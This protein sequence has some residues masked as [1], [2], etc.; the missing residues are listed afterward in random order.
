VGGAS[1][2]LWHSH[3]LTE[4]YSAA[5][6]DEVSSFDDYLRLEDRLFAELQEDVYADVG[7]GPAYALVRY[8]A[9]SLADPEDDEPNW[10]RSFELATEA[11]V[12]G[13]LLLHGMSDSP[14]SLRA[15]AETLA[16]QG[17]W[18]IGL[19]LP[20]H[21]TAPSGLTH[22]TMQEMAGAVRLAM[23]HLASKLGEKP[24]H[25]VGYSTGAGLALDFALDEIEGKVSPKPASLVLI[26]PAIRIH[27]SAALARFKDG[28][29]IVPGLGGLAWLQVVPEFDQFIRDQCRWG[30]S[31]PHSIRRS[32]HCLSIPP[33]SG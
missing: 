19:R 22:I 28:L 21:G 5:N 27:P 24:V 1:L 25:I 18:V 16:E 9:G 29:S 33:R 23:K 32:A 15:L 30:G 31:P 20:G 2:E 12:G 17:Y 3:R 11:P 13:V 10:N 4:E 26:S 8:S 7:T 6:R 14:Y